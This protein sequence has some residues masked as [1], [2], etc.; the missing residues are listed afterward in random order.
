MSLEAILAAVVASG[1]GQV[2]EIEA[3]AQ[4]RAE[5]ILAAARVEAERLRQEARSAVAGQASKESTRL[6]YDARLE[7]LQIVGNVRDG[8]VDEA[9]QRTRQYLANV[10]SDPIYPGVMRQLVEEAL[11]VLGESMRTSEQPQLSADPRDRGLMEQALRQMGLDLLVSYELNCQGG[12]VARSED[13]RVVAINTLDSR[14]E[15]AVPYLRR[16]LT[17]LFEEAPV[18][19]SLP[20][21]QT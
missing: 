9:L 2:R 12:L 21:Q 10:R 20:V 1:E 15:R 6:M 17:A 4:N 18:D 5:D 13:G 16:V 11:H 3:Q 19:S 8:L 14:L 7:A